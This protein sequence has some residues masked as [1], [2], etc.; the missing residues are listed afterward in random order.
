[1]GVSVRRLSGWE[2]AEVTT[3]EYDGDLLVRSVTVREPEWASD[4]VAL[5]LALRRLEADMGPHGVPMSEATDL[6]NRGKFI[7]NEVPKV[8]YA[9]LAIDKAREHHYTEFPKAKDDQSAH[10]WYIK[11][12]DD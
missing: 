6:A 4:D 1:L 12:R 11:G 7:V 2:P 9:R 3:F 10:I 8:D 5:L